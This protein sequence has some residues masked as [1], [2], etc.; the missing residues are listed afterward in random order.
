VIFEGTC[1][2]CGATIQVEWDPSQGIIDYTLDENDRMATWVR[3]YAKAP[4]EA[5]P[6]CAVYSSK[7][8]EVD[9]GPIGSS[10]PSEGGVGPR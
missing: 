6:D 4:P 5:N 3:H 1:D 2:V 7:V 10:S 8:Y 9:E